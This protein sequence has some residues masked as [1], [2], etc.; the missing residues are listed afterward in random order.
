MFQVVLRISYPDNLVCCVFVFFS[1]GCRFGHVQFETTEGA[2]LAVAMAGTDI[3]GRAIRVDYA[4]ERT[5]SSGGG[6]GGFS[7]GGD[8]GGRGGGF[9]RGGDRGMIKL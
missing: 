6:R 5:G 1:R 3:D 7:R 8:R 4:A 9:S 2:E